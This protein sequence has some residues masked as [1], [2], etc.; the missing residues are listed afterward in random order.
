MSSR[1]DPSASSDPQRS[2]DPEL[3]AG[4]PYVRSA[5]ESDR[6]AR[7][8]FHLGLFRSLK[9][10]WR[11]AVCV[12][13]LCLV[14]IGAYLLRMLP[15]YVAH[16][17]VTIQIARQVAPGQRLP[18]DGS[19]GE[20]YLQQQAQ[21][22]AGNDVLVGAVHRLPDLVWRRAGES[23]SSAADRLE[24]ALS[25]KPIGATSQVSIAVHAGNATLAAQLANAVA[26]SFV[27]H[28]RQGPHPA[29][30]HHVNLL[31]EER[32]RV[33][34]EL[35]ADR[36]EQEDLAKML[37]SS[38]V[39]RSAVQPYAAQFNELR[40]ELSKA[41]AA[42]DDAAAHLRNMG[43]VD[44]R[45]TAALDAETDKL[46][47][48]DP[49][50]VSLKTSL[51]Q[52][53]AALTDQLRN[54]TADKPLFK[55]DS[56]EMGQI[57]ASLDSLMKDMHAKAHVELEQKLQ[58]ELEQTSALE[59]RLNI[60]MAK[61]TVLAGNTAPRVDRAADLA[62]D[63]VRLQSR[64]TAADEQLRI[65]S[66]QNKPLQFSA[67]LS[68]AA[69]PPTHS[70]DNEVLFN[71][72]LLALGSLVLAI[73]AAVA[74]HKSDLR[75]HTAEVEQEKPPIAA[76][77]EP[78]AD[79]V[80]SDQSISPPGPSASLPQSPAAPSPVTAS[81][82]LSESQPQPPAMPMRGRG[83]PTRSSAAQLSQS[84]T[85]TRLRTADIPAPDPRYD[86]GTVPQPPVDPLW[87]DNVPSPLAVLP[88][89]SLAASVLPAEIEDNDLPYSAA[90]RLGSLRN[91][92][93]PSKLHNLH[94]EVQARTPS[95]ASAERAERDAHAPLNS[96]TYPAPTADKLGT[97]PY[98]VRVIALPEF[99]LPP[100]PDADTEPPKEPLRAVPT[101][102]RRD[103]P[104]EIE[105]L[106][107][108]RGQY[109]KRR[110]PPV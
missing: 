75:I 27:D 104:D 65:L 69:V 41:R 12:F 102:P 56:D 31:R 77:A 50:L 3:S 52:R 73:A 55:Q 109:R 93:G 5:R 74:A 80:T 72:L 1:Q 24:R 16:S 106:P 87:S 59:A 99:L 35:E 37:S 91:L 103:A 36:A 44:V 92:F 107:S 45:S 94:R 105:T 78:A 71:A 85:G 7:P 76:A 38:A 83:D 89:A 40:S 39:G 48:A 95:P 51:I 20:A 29:D 15:I 17:V 97:D 60:Q 54:L 4:L 67:Y 34:K 64:F 101:P 57:T 82:A 88:P 32:D 25:V 98:A 68:S 6:G 47:A 11:F 62:T 10:R 23:D 21:V 61:L 90:A 46:I 79:S 14:L 43:S 42:S 22:I 110:Y 81:R 58:D 86:S 19:A 53:R 66:L 108:W 49:G 8:F 26:D 9:L 70:S 100:R 2:D 30:P 28:S 18:L 13:A 84:D 63:I 96:G 33:Q